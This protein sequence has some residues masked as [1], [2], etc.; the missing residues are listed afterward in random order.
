M[1]FRQGAEIG[2]SAH[3]TVGDKMAAG[4]RDP[5]LFSPQYIPQTQPWPYSLFHFFSLPD[6]ARSIVCF[7]ALRHP[8]KNGKNIE[9]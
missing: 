6:P 2:I 5:A 7:P 8:K 4:A 9:S 1:Q 3:L